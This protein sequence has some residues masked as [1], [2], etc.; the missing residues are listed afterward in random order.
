[1]TYYD[2]MLG[3]NSQRTHPGDSGY[4]TGKRTDAINYASF[5]LGVADAEAGTEMSEA[6]WRERLARE[7]VVE[8]WRDAPENESAERAK[9]KCPDYGLVPFQEIAE[10]YSRVAD[11]GAGKYSAWNWTK[12]LPRAQILASLM[13]HAFAYL[14]GEDYDKESTLSHAD[15]ILWN[16]AA[17]V[18]NIHHDLEDG[19]RTEPARGYKND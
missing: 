11:Y 6:R 10:S 8:D 19:R 5:D 13:R 3:H 9:L 14:R 7:G 1:M 2:Y 17:L 4:L 15:H 16:A 12:G 18:H